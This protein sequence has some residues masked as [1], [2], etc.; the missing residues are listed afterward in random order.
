[1]HIEEMCSCGRVKAYRRV[2]LRTVNE[3]AV[4]ALRSRTLSSFCS[5]VNDMRIKMHL[6][7]AEAVS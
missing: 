5:H 4:L 7:R 1:M 3:P 6:H 2:M